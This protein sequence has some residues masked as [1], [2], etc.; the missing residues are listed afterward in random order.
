MPNRRTAAII[1][2]TGT[3]RRGIVRVLHGAG[4]VII[5][6]ARDAG[7]LAALASEFGGAITTVAGSVADDAAAARVAA[8]V[9]RAAPS[10][11][12]V[13]T[14][15]NVPPASQ[16]LLDMSADA[17]TEMFRGNV[18][19]HL[20][21]AKAFLPLMA[22]GGRYLGLGGGMA[23]F[24]FDGMGGV[25]M[26]QAA[27]RNL[28]RFLAQESEGHKV[29]V[30]ELMLFSHI[31]DPADTDKA[32]PRDMRADEVGAHVLAVLERPAE[33]AGPILTLNSRKQV[34]LPERAQ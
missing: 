12:A 29:S 19:T 4:W 1:G 31:V 9:H 26:C 15:V 34:G 28:F 21:A 5:A 17:L 13:I 25:S 11:D 16:C 10:L 32:E 6:V 23:D 20:C 27:Q 8:D 2:A 3:V 33:F 18:V 30:V 14:T 7:R 24:T 22:A